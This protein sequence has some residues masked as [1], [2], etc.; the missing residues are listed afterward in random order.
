MP[1]GDWFIIIGLSLSFV[2]SIIF[3]WGLWVSKSEIPDLS[4]AANTREGDPYPIETDDRGNSKPPTN[5]MLV[6]FFE[7]QR[8]LFR[9]GFIPLSLGF[10]LQLIG[11]F[12]SL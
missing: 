1:V 7:H 2:G 4:R 11:Y 5:P 6:R 9:L 10:L 12:L 3:G 8:R